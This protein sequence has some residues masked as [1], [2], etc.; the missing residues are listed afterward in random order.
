MALVKA[1]GGTSVRTETL[2]DAYPAWHPALYDFEGML[3]ILMYHE[4]TDESY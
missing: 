4:I 2:E 3:R 1:I